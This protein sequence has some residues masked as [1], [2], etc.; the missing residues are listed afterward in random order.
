MR[1][2]GKP[3]EGI[4]LVELTL[5]VARSPGKIGNRLYNGDTRQCLHE[6]NVFTK[7][8]LIC[9]VLHSGMT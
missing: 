9:T 7:P 6:I 3:R 1:N 2:T 4:S 5:D 8:V